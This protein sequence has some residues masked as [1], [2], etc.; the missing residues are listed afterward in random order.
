MKERQSRFELGVAV[1]VI[2][3]IVLILLLASQLIL[4][5]LAVPFTHMWIYF[6]DEGGLAT[7]SSDAFRIAFA[8]HTFGSHSRSGN[9]IVDGRYAPR[10]FG[11]PDSVRSEVGDGV[12]YKYSQRRRLLTFQYQGHEI[13]YSHALKKLTVDGQEYSTTGGQVSLLVKESGEVGELDK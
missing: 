12:S 9:Y 13:V 11:G 7:I 4:D 8:G 5:R 2:C 3:A 6:E 1:L 10:L